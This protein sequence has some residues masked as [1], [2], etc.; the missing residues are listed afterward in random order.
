MTPQIMVD[1]SRRSRVVIDF[2]V[3]CP[4][5]RPPQAKAAAS[6]TVDV[7]WPRLL[8]PIVSMLRTQNCSGQLGSYA[9]TPKLTPVSHS[10]HMPRISTDSVR[11]FRLA[12]PAAP[13]RDRSEE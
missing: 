9:A 1:A 7:P 6:Q 13:R 3:S 11:R 5:G 10:S 2:I 8:S 12:F 4:L